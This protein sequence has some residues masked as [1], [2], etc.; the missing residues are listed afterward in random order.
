MGIKFD[1]TEGERINYYLG[2]NLDD[3]SRV[4]AVTATVKDI[5]ENGVWMSLENDQENEY[6]YAYVDILLF[7][8]SGSTCLE[9]TKADEVYALAARLGVDPLPEQNYLVRIPKQ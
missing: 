3:M 7:S 2:V 9:G 1:F 8:R 4:E 5:E 6:F